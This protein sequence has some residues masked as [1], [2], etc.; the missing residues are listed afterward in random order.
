MSE[1]VSSVGGGRRRWLRATGWISLGA[2]AGLMAGGASVWAWGREGAGFGRHSFFHG[3]HRGPVDPAEAREHVAMG[4]KWALRGVNAT[5]DQ[6]QRV[7]DIAFDAIDDLFPL[8]DRHHA[9]REALRAALS[10]AKVDR[11]ALEEARRAELKLADEA[12]ARL[13]E[14]IADAAEVLTPEQRAELAQM[15]QRFHR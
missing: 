3:R 8:R 11:Q 7:R 4:V 9:N 6:Q 1:S 10:G 13:L 12:S 5:E 2:V 15:A 14:A